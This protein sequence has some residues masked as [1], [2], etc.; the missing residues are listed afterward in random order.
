MFED[1]WFMR[2]VNTLARTVALLVF[3][4]RETTY[5]VGVEGTLSETDILYGK[6]NKLVEDGRYN[7]AENL[8]FENLD[9]RNMRYLELAV[10]FYSRLN[11]LSN[12]ELES[13]GF[14]RSEVDEGLREVTKKYQ[15]DLP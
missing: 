5:Q 11:E 12:D 14:S 10:D 4:K 13:H 9:V 2:Q 6:L 3:R 1:D 8:L 15:V 7:E